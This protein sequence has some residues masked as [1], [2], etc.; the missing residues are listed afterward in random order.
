MFKNIRFFLIGVVLGCIL[1]LS[2]GALAAVGKTVSAIADEYI[3]F[4]IDGEKKELPE[5]YT[6]LLYEGRTYVP[7]RFVS[8]SLGADVQWVDSERAV[9]I[10]SQKPLPFPEEESMPEDTAEEERAETEQEDLETEDE[11]GQPKGD[12]REMPV[13]AYYEDMRLTAYLVMLER[14]HTRVY[15]DLENEDAPPL[16]ILQGETVAVVDGKEYN[17]ADV[18][19]YMRDER[20]YYDVRAEET[21][22]GYLSLPLIEEDGEEMKLIVTVLNNDRTQS[23]RKVELDIALDVQVGDI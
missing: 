16:Q 12:Y 11:T 5:G 22:N 9:R 19:F 20:W 7:T 3:S 13:T 1:M 23:T 15:I 8:E 18:P 21:R 2:P 10:T 14:G 4:E 17:A 6:V